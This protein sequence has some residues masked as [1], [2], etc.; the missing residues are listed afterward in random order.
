MKV[1]MV[2]SNLHIAGGV[3][4]FAMKYYKNIDHNKIAMDFILYD[5]SDPFNEYV[6]EIKKHGDHIYC[7]PPLKNINEHLKSC[8]NILKRGKYDVIHDNSLINTI[9]LMRE[10]KKTKIPVR[11][12][13]AHATRLGQNKYKELRNKFFLPIL[14]K[15]INTN[16]ACSVEAAKC[17]FGNDKYTLLH[18]AIHGEDY[19]FDKEKRN[20]FRK[21]IGASDKKIV[22]TVGRVAEQKNPYFAIDVIAEAIK[23]NNNIFYIWVGDGPLI[24]N[25][26]DYVDSLHLSEYIQFVGNKTNLKRYY[27]AADC[28]FLPSLFEGL[29]VSGVE[30]QASGIPC[31]FSDTITKELSYIDAVKYVSLSKSEIYWAEQ[32][33]DYLNKDIDRNKGINYFQLSSFSDKN[34]GERLEKFYKNELGNTE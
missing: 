10:A 22:L 4:R 15:S 13:H 19:F 32:L 31:I 2:V 30:A 24:N 7:L 34:A 3:A 21:Q 28:F 16:A 14:K 5:N 9:P 12:L 26:K 6:D 11:V 27:L 8:R 23:R 17:L 20:E 1:L 29:P 18:N 33:L 25:L